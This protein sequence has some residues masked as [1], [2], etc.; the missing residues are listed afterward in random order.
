MLLTIAIIGLTLSL[1]IS[2]ITSISYSTEYDELSIQQFFYIL[3]DDLLFSSDVSV[4]HNKL[5]LELHSDEKA[6]IE[7]YG[8]V[9]RR[10]VEGKGHEVYLREV[11]DV[12]FT[13]LPYGI[14]ATIT[15]LEGETYEKT[16]IFYQ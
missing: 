1:L 12:M 15:S 10:Q 16:I 13:L 9:I 4:E 6:T 7:Q 14:E 11:E 8:R 2:L 5:Y 3:R